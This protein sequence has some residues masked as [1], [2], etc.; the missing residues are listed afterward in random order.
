MA[1]P[2]VAQVHHPILAPAQLSAELRLS[3]QIK[4]KKK[5]LDGV[6]LGSGSAATMREFSGDSLTV[7]Q[8]IPEG[9]ALQRQACQP[10]GVVLPHTQP[11]V[12]GAF[13]PARV[14]FLQLQMSTRLHTS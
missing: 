1:S 6:R 11:Q 10:R 13:Q 4:K 7:Q 12:L 9:A 5:T 14:P 2:A 3:C 8:H